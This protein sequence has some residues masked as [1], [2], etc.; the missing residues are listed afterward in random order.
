[1]ID[2]ARERSIIFDCDDEVTGGDFDYQSYVENGFETTGCGA[3]IGYFFFCSY[4][5]V[6]P[7]IFLNLFIAI[8]L[9]G[10]EDMN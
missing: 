3:P 2:S 5:L 4:I 6:V 7:L 10:F 9:Q 8:I 1:M